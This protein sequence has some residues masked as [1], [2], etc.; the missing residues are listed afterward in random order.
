MQS[1][2]VPGSFTARS[3][4]SCRNNFCQMSSKALRVGPPKW[5]GVESQADSM[6]RATAWGLTQRFFGSRLKNNQRSSRLPRGGSRPGAGRK[7]GVPNRRTREMLEQ[8]SAG[9]ELPLQYM[10]RIMRDGRVSPARR[11]A[12]AKAAAQFCHSRLTVAAGSDEG[13]ALVSG[14]PDWE[15]LLNPRTSQLVMTSVDGDQETVCI[16]RDQRD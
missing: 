15:K 8:S 12:M 1:L 14:H 9:G 5:E 13:P 7:Q 6:G 4:F 2:S 11:D 10:L 16:P 3:V